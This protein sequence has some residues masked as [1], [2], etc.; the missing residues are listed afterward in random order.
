MSDLATQLSQVVIFQGLDR[1]QLQS[2][3]HVA[4]MEQFEP[5]AG[6]FQEGDPGSELYL[7]LDGKVRISRKLPTGGEEALAILGEGQA[8]GEMAVID[9]DLVRSATAVAHE[10]CFMIVIQKDPFQALLHKDQALACT[11]LWNVVKLQSQRL[12]DTNDKMVFLSTT[13]MF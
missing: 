8:F 5:E 7:I 2:I 13:G 10:P 1:A 11:V 3:L 9:D 6:I 4:G 12:R